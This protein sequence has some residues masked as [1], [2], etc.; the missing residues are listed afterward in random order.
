MTSKTAKAWHTFGAAIGIGLA[1]AVETR[2]LSGFPVGVAAWRGVLN[3]CLSA[4]IVAGAG[5]WI[6]GRPTTPPNGPT[7]G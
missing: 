4:V 2:F 3:L 1:T 5:W 6:R 7:A